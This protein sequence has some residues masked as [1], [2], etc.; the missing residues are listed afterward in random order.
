MQLFIALVHLAGNFMAEA[1]LQPST[2]YS[3][4][5]LP[6]CSVWLHSNGTFWHLR[7]RATPS[8]WWEYTGTLASGA[9]G[10]VWRATKNGDRTEEVVIKIS[11]AEDDAD[12][13]K[14]ANM[15][16]DLRDTRIVPKLVFFCRVALV[17]G[18][19]NHR[20][21]ENRLALV[22]AFGGPSLRDYNVARGILADRETACLVRKALKVLK[23]MY[24]RNII[25]LDIKPD[26]LLLRP[27]TNGAT[28]VC[29]GELLIIDFGFARYVGSSIPVGTFSYASWQLITNYGPT[30]HDDLL[31]MAISISEV[32]GWMTND[33]LKSRGEHAEGARKQSDPRILENWDRNFIT[34]LRA[35]Q[36]KSKSGALLRLIDL[37]EIAFCVSDFDYDG[38]IK[39]VGQ[40]VIRSKSTSPSTVKPKRGNLRGTKFACP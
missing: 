4:G 31:S 8:Q 18:V 2:Y 16:S 32:S 14:E 27:R 3:A 12:F 6:K 11:N 21:Y 38:L 39:L 10:V 30:Y 36:E 22:S 5:S 25:H 24:I 19:A 13:I 29:S 9:Q 26:N 40:T 15:F 34:A 37:Y 35:K 23:E 20:S 17:F 28:D 1:A 33:E 7:T